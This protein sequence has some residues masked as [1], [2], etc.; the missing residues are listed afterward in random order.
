MV[1]LQPICVSNS[2]NTWWVNQNKGIVSDQVH[3]TSAVGY[4]H[5][6][7]SV[8]LVRKDTGRKKYAYRWHFIRFRDQRNAHYIMGK[9]AYFDVTHLQENLSL[10][11][12]LWF[13]MIHMS[14]VSGWMTVGL[15]IT[16]HKKHRTSDHLVSSSYEIPHKFSCTMEIVRDLQIINQ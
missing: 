3:E 6:S 2:H 15:P 9:T 13:R 10:C 12:W 11:C 7:H 14:L 4:I 5:S 1:C 8:V 16:H